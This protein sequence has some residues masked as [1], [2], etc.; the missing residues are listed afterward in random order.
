MFDLTEKSTFNTT[1]LKL[2]I[3][4]SFWKRDSELQPAA[5]RTRLFLGAA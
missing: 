4:V 5:T 2:I 1:Q 3:V